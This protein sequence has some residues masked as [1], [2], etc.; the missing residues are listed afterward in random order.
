MQRRSFLKNS[1]SALLFGVLSTNKVLASTISTLTPE[2]LNVLLYLIQNKNGDWKVK[3]TKWTDIKSA[4]LSKL[5]YNLNTFTPLDIVDNSI[6][7]NVKEKYWKEYNCKGRCPKNV[8]YLSSYKTG[9]KAKESGQ[10]AEA[11]KLS[12]GASHRI[13][14]E[15][16]EEH[17]KKIGEQNK[18]N[19]HMDFLHKNWGKDLGKNWGKV[20]ADKVVREKLGIHGAPKQV[21][22]KWAS[23]AGKIGGKVTSSKYDMNKFSKL[24]NM[25]NI[26]KHGKRLYAHNKKTYEVIEFDSIGQAERYSGIQSVTITK[27]L[28]GLQPQTRCGWTFIKK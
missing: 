24:G 23:N 4:R 1:I 13:H 28:R 16:W 2:S 26:K 21:R 19:G 3:G 17:G 15:Y 11:H 10:L 7:N 9:L 20:G 8:N 25:A 6:V 18:E 5:Y 27:I 22:I 12:L 14:P